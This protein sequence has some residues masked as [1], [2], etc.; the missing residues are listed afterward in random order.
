MLLHLLLLLATAGARVLSS[1]RPTGIS[2]H[3]IISLHRPSVARSSAPVCA[4]GLSYD[5][6]SESFMDEDEDEDMAYGMSVLSAA[7]AREA[8]LVASDSMLPDVADMLSDWQEEQAIADDGVSPMCEEEM[9]ASWRKMLHAKERELVKT[10]REEIRLDGTFLP[11]HLTGWRTHEPAAGDGSHGG[12]E[13]EEAEVE[14]LLEADAE[15]ADVLDDAFIAEWQL[16]AEQERARASSASTS[17]AGAGPASLLERWMDHSRGKASKKGVRDDE[18]STIGI[19]LGTTNC[20]VAAVLNGKPSII[21]M[22][23]GERVFPSIVS[24]LAPSSANASG[25]VAHANAPL[26]DPNSTSRVLCGE[27][28]RRQFVTNRWSTYS[29]TKRLIGRTAS[30]EELRQLC[31]LDV[32]HSITPNTREVLLACPALRRAV[33]PVSI[34][35]ELVREIRVRAET[36]LQQPLRNAVVTVPAYFDDSQRCATQT[37]CMLAGLERVRLLREPEAAALNFALDC[38]TDTRVM[39]FDLGGGTFDVSILDVGSGV[40]EVVASSGDPR[41]GGNDWDNVLTAWLEEQFV[42]EHGRALNGFARRRL[43]DAAE[44]AKIALSTATSVQVDVPFLVDDAGLNVT[45]SRRKFEALCRSLLLRLVPPMREVVEMAGLELDETRM[46]TLVKGFIGNS[47]P[48]VQQWQQQVA[49]RWRRLAQ[50]SGAGASLKREALGVPISR[51]L[52]VGGAT[53]M[54]SIGR[55]IKRMTGLTVKPSVHPEEAVALGAA[56]QA[57]VLDGTIEQK[58]FNPLQHERVTRKLVDDPNIE[59]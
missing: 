25:T 37:A 51:V 30:A 33:S 36:T 7:A 1:S 21:P 41:L 43:L 40:V 29:S 19:D 28:A 2:L 20:A 5:E 46:G 31:A 16:H 38:K 48:Q 32:P 47:A 52:L 8:A 4:I 59:R 35:A 12:A 27:A 53:R 26:L 54:P 11:A 58:V 34:A 3:R 55:F 17:A 23:D 56:V 45:L 50:K 10:R 18:D 13:E 15:G 39:V 44:D 42:A 6:D 22:P 9:M 14:A 57:G 49:W 24:F